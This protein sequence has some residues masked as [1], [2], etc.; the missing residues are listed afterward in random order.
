MIFLPKNPNFQKN[1]QNNPL[2]KLFLNIPHFEEEAP[3]E[4]MPA[5]KLK[6]EAP[7]GLASPPYVGNP[8]DTCVLS[9]KGGANLSDT[10]VFRNF[11]EK[12]C[13]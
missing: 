6:E 1:I 11:F 2:L 13:T 5:L 3:D 10:C 7:I 4:L 12:Y 8:I 9:F